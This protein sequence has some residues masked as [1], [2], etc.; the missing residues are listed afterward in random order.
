MKISSILA[1]SSMA[2]I[3]ADAWSFT[4]WTEDYQKGKHMH[5]KSMVADNN[6]YP[7]PDQITRER[8]GS[9]TFCSAAWTRCSIT[10]HS[11]PGC[12]GDKLGSATAGSPK[13]WYKKSTSKEGSYMKSFRIQGCKKVPIADLDVDVT[14]CLDD[15]S[16]I[17]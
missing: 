14:K 1:F 16:Y 4:V 9:F 5:F 13:E 6:C 10:I 15:P 3:G 11:K 17:H 2:L 12:I 8:V 7:I